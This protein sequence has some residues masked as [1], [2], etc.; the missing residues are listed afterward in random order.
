M[1]RKKHY[2]AAVIF[3]MFCVYSGVKGWHDTED[4][5]K[6][7]GLQAAPVEITPG[8]AVYDDVVGDQITALEEDNR[9]DQGMMA[10]TAEICE[11]T[12]TP[13]PSRTCDDFYEIRVLAKAM[14]AVNV[15]FPQ[16]V[17]GESIQAMRENSRC[18]PEVFSSWMETFSHLT[19]LLKGKDG[20]EMLV[21]DG[22]MTADETL[23]IRQHLHIHYTGVLPSDFT[24]PASDVPQVAPASAALA[25]SY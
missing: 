20:T 10:E 4:R 21:K 9:N 22:I 24:R 6:A 16:V 18:P 8:T 1:Q 17:M 3:T 12:R 14:R 7:F 19:R 11:S 5:E 25:R 15:S 2:I 23:M 13:Y